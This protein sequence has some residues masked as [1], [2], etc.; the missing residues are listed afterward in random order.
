MDGLW[1]KI[2]T[3]LS[4]DAW[5]LLMAAARLRAGKPSGVFGGAFPLASGQMLIAVVSAALA[6]HFLHV[7][8]SLCAGHQWTSTHTGTP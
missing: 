8:R 5:L 7:Q 6:Q 3:K 2:L 4:L 1:W